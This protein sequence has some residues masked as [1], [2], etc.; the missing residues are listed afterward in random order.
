[1]QIEHLYTL[2]RFVYSD[3]AFLTRIWSNPHEQTF[4]QP[5]MKQSWNPG[6][7]RS[8]KARTEQA[9]TPCLPPPLSPYEQKQRTCLHYVSKRTFTALDYLMIIILMP[10]LL[11]GFF[12]MVTVAHTM[13]HDYCTLHSCTVLWDVNLEFSHLTIPVFNTLRPLSGLTRMK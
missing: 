13:L 3:G 2:G 5:I 9:P 11:L 12:I 6:L 7:E 10:I 4:Q 1:M 8:S